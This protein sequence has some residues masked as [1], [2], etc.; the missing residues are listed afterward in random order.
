MYRY[1]QICF[2]VTFALFALAFGILGCT[3]LY[4]AVGVSDKTIQV[5]QADDELQ[6]VEN[7]GEVRTIFWESVS[8]GVALLGGLASGYLGLKLRTSNKINTA[9]ILGV[10]KK[11]D[12]TTKAVI[13]AEAVELGIA[14]ALHT[15][16]K[17]LTG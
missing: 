4:K 9:V 12:E 10:E 13:H 14:D 2:V 17:L 16:V 7:V 5:W 15:K 8:A 3:K 6:I 1:S 11:G